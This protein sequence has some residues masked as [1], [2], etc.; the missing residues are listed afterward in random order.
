MVLFYSHA[1]E[2]N[3]NLSDFLCFR[4]LWG[5]ESTILFPESSLHSLKSIVNSQFDQ[6]DPS[7]FSLNLLISLRDVHLRS[8]LIQLVHSHASNIYRIPFPLSYDSFVFDALQASAYQF[9]SSRF[10]LNRLLAGTCLLS[11]IR[12]GV[13][14]ECLPVKSSCFLNSFEIKKRISQLHLK[15]PAPLV[16]VKTSWLKSRSIDYWDVNERMSFDSFFFSPSREHQDVRTLILPDSN[17]GIGDYIWELSWLIDVNDTFSYSILSPSKSH[18]LLNSILNA[19]LSSADLYQLVDDR[20][21]ESYSRVTCMSYVFSDF[22]SRHDFNLPIE[23]MTAINS[24]QKSVNSIRNI[25]VH[26]YSRNKN[27]NGHSYG[28]EWLCGFYITRMF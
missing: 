18:D 19:N 20:S 1:L 12:H 5:C 22:M 9:L 14:N 8:M 11:A 23:K 26:L 7:A 15:S 6:I 16:K 25:G 13:D 24:L 10:D 28:S 27:K 21:R 4:F 17:L 2:K 3:I